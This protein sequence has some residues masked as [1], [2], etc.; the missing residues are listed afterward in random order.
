[1]VQSPP[2]AW[3]I[4]VGRT[5]KMKVGKANFPWAIYNQDDCYLWLDQ[6]DFPTSLF[7]YQRQVKK[8]SH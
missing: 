7:Q 4:A 6:D 2:S 5:G 1:V 8:R 3:N